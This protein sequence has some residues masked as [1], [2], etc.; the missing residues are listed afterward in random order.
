MEGNPKYLTVVVLGNTPFHKGR[1]FKERRAAWEA[2]GPYLHY[3][4]AY[5]PQLKLIEPVWRKLKGF[6]MPR[7]C[8]DNLEQPSAQD[9]KP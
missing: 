3:L 8:Y 6:L 1:H 5:C 2:K 9:L 7:R 4:P